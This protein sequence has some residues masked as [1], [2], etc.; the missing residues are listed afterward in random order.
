VSFRNQSSELDTPIE[1]ADVRGKR[2]GDALKAEVK[3]WDEAVTSR[4]EIQR[5]NRSKRPAGRFSFWRLFH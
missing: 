5:Q 1:P 4:I 3:K 2:L